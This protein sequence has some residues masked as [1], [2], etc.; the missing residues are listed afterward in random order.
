MLTVRMLGVAD[1]EARLAVEPLASPGA[2]ARSEDPP[3]R[4]ANTMWVGSAE[5]LG[6]LGL[7]EGTE[8]TI[9]ALAA[10]VA[11]R[12]A[13]SGAQARVD[14]A[15]FDLTFLAPPSVSWVWAMAQ[16]ELRAKMEGAVTNAAYFSLQYLVGTKLRVDHGTSTQGFA[17][18]LA[19]HAVGQPRPQGEAP[20]PLLHV[21]GYLVG[22]LDECGRLC[23]PRR[24]SLYEDDVLL[25]SGAFGRA[26]L[27]EEL[28]GIGFGTEVV[29]GRDGLPS[30]EIVGVAEGLLRVGESADKGCAGLGLETHR[31]PRENNPGHGDPWESDPWE[32]D[33]WDN[34]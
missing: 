22:I 18:A 8:A 20:P 6:C 33:P 26:K 31:E 15:V 7:K 19:L 27:A 4:L 29:T 21:H 23:G 14:G 34:V 17:A 10:A 24:S 28:R 3:T 1:D 2:F 12:H 13:M 16:A 5:V 32:S 30:F 11:G 25:A 9:G